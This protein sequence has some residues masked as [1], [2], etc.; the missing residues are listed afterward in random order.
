M[1]KA[2]QSR[3]CR[4]RCQM[5]RS[6]IISKPKPIDRPSRPP[7]RPPIPA[8]VLFLTSCDRCV[9]FVRT[10]SFVPIGCL[11]SPQTC[12]AIPSFPPSPV[13]LSLHF[14][15]ITLQNSR[16]C[17]NK[18]VLNLFIHHK[19]GTSHQYT[20]AP[21]AHDQLIRPPR[22]L[23]TRRRSQTSKLRQ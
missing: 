22:I 23:T 17:A 6:P 20:S 7:E 19:R 10:D 9:H 4:S 13:A 21:K 14:P 3:P 2:N 18:T 12:Y 11:L 15:C 5:S 1:G 8:A 16:S